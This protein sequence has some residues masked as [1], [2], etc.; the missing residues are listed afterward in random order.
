MLVLESEAPPSY[1]APCTWERALKKC[2]W[3]VL[4]IA[5]A[6]TATFAQSSFDGTWKLDVDSLP[7]PKATLA[8]LLQDG[9]YECKSCRPP[10]RV[11]ADGQDQAV[12]GQPYDTISV[13]VLD[14]RTV[15]EIEKTSG[16]IVSDEKFTVSLDR[17]TA[18]DEFAGWKVIMRR[19]DEAPP[20][21]HALSGAWR[22]FK[23]ESTSD[24]ALLITYKVEGD[25]LY[26]NRP[27]GQSYA[28]RL[29]GPEAPYNGAPGVTSV[30]VRR[31]DARTIEETD[32]LDGKALSVLRITVTSDGKSMIIAVTQ[33]AIGATTELTAKKQ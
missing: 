32:K 8:W 33:A 29:D 22:P 14:D 15:R 13:S 5:L 9:I 16:H 25:I 31:I 3:A 12:T 10:I 7:F 19:D 26:M 21:S 2:V 17:K 27:S 20:G 24:Q 6:P 1:H 30:S 28:A 11:K 23:L 4:L 18:T